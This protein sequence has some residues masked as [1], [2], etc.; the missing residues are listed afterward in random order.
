M[1]QEFPAIFFKNFKKILETWQLDGEQCDLL[2]VGSAGFGQVTED[3][4]DIDLIYIGNNPEKFRERISTH[5][6]L[7]ALTGEGLLIECL[8]YDD[9][10][11]RLVEAYINKQDKGIEYPPALTEIGSFDMIFSE[12]KRFV[13][14]YWSTRP[15]NKKFDALFKRAL[16]LQ[17]NE[18]IKD[19]QHAKLSN[20]RF[21]ESDFI[22]SFDKYLQRLAKR[23]I[24][25]PQEIHKL[26][27]HLL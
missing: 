14:K 22:N 2:L 9:I 16:L 15:V 27:A 24:E 11:V 26:L 7:S 10:D 19:L 20:F 25:F 1:R 18:V 3:T 8:D 13:S 5:E 17:D 4:H 21:K 23:N 12:F 6:I